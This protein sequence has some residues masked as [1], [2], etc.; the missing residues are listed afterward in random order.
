M[1]GGV[2]QENVCLIGLMRRVE[3]GM[4]SLSVNFRQFINKC[5]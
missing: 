2:E 3:I 4:L 1:V 5:T